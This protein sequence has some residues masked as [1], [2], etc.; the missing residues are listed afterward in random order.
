MAG[1]IN[2][3]MY[4]PHAPGAPPPVIHPPIVL[5]PAP[6]PVVEPPVI[7]PPVDQQPVDQQPVVQQPVDD[8]IAGAPP[9][10]QQQEPLFIGPH[11]LVGPRL[12][13]I[14]D[15]VSN[16]PEIRRICSEISIFLSTNANVFYV[17]E[18]AHSTSNAGIRS[19]ISINEFRKATDTLF[20]P[21]TFIEP[22]KFFVRN[23]TKPNRLPMY[24][25][26]ISIAALED[27][28]NNTLSDANIE[29]ASSADVSSR[30]P[31]FMPN[32][33]LNQ[34]MKRVYRSVQITGS[35]PHLDPL[36]HI[37]LRP[38]EGMI[39][40]NIARQYVNLVLQLYRRIQAILV[41]NGIQQGGKKK[42]RRTQKV[43]NKQSSKQSRKQKKVNSKQSK[44][45]K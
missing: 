35:I 15:I 1:N 36:Y 45:R 34:N 39:E 29:R 12:P 10:P 5:P 18:Y 17:T 13:P 16:D 23:A 8:N 20:Y 27:S 19:P 24:N 40:K 28:L 30:G 22:V 31:Y 43:N 6:P 2:P 3:D 33:D 9:P 44:K 42:R 38:G 4:F 37:L 32:V 41:E 7:H 26:Q 21:T 14:D 11:I 25:P